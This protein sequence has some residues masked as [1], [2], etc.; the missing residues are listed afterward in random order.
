[1]CHAITAWLACSISSPTDTLKAD[2]VRP[3]Y[4]EV[5]FELL[6]WKLK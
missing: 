1:M 5:T 6:L 4:F 2:L 3:D